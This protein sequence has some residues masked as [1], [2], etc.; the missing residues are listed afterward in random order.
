MTPSRNHWAITAR[1][2]S[3]DPFGRE[4][5]AWRHPPAGAADTV[6]DDHAA[7]TRAA[8]TLRELCDARS[9]DAAVDLARPIQQFRAR[10]LIHFAAEEAED[11]FES[12]VKSQPGLV[13][14][15]MHL[16]G[17]HAELAFAL[18]CLFVLAK[19]APR[20]PELAA[21]LVRFL[22]RFELHEHAEN[23]LLQ[24]LLLTDEGC[25]G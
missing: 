10:L 23:A 22:D 5:F 2:V 1:E 21:R 4:A 13:Q 15:A 6:L 16:Q 12:V 11:F 24:E 7:L 9:N 14:R 8:K 3:T 20:K 19:T 18:E 25:G 17:E